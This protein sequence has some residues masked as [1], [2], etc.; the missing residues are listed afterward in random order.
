MEFYH[1]TLKQAPE[2]L[3]Y[4]KARGIDQ[5][6]AIDTFK[7]GVANRTLG[8]RL[9]EKTRKAGAELR[10]RLEGLGL[11]RDQARALQWQPGHSDPGRARP[12]D[13][14]LRPQDHR[15]AAAGNATA[16]VPGVNPKTG[17]VG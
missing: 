1:Q 14:D 5:A 3:A 12:R 16:P 13:R 4:L 17:A 15:A 8:L 2:A 7:L 9:P 11:Y 10:A 6:Q